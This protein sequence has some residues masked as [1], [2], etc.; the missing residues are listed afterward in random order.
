MDEFQLK[1]CGSDLAE[2]LVA[3]IQYKDEAREA[4][5]RQ[6]ARVAEILAESEASSKAKAEER[7][8]EEQSEEE[9]RTR[10]IDGLFG[11]PEPVTT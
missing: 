10:C 1:H 11:H 6:D 7:A 2:V 4:Q 9:E 3:L 5:E 8:R